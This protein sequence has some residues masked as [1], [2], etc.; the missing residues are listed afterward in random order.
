MI[1]VYLNVVVQC[2]FSCFVIQHSSANQCKSTVDIRD[3]A[4]FCWAGKAKV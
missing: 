1:S 4:T 2:Y 3:T